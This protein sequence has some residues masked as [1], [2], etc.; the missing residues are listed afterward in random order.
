MAQERESS[1]TK[2]FENLSNHKKEIIYDLF[3]IEA[4]QFGEFTLSG[5]EKSPYYFNS[6]IINQFP[7]LKRSVAEEYRDL[8]LPLRNDPDSNFKYLSP[9]PT[10]ALIIA[11]TV[12]DMFEVGI[13]V[14]N[15]VKKNH[16]IPA[17]IIGVPA[18]YNRSLAVVVEDSVTRGGSILKAIDCLR[19]GNVI[20]NDVAVLF[21]REQGGVNKIEKEA[22]VKV[23]RILNASAVFDFAYNEGFLH[24]FRYQEIK[25]YIESKK[26]I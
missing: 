15:L 25:S 7:H 9:V 4:F 8:L 11:S 26:P 6:R 10:G 13:I 14:P 19:K 1:Q 12:A 23:H 24:P 18:L 5:G 2:P 16:G 22:E 17:D 3:D 21:D 20:V